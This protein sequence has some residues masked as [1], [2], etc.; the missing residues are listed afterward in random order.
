M[1]TRLS[2]DEKIEALKR[3]SSGESATSVAN[4]IGVSVQTVCNWKK[5]ASNDTTANTLSSRYKSFLNGYMD[6]DNGKITDDAAAIEP[7]TIEIESAPASNAKVDNHQITLDEYVD[8]KAVK[9]DSKVETPKENI[10]NATKNGKRTISL[11][12]HP[13]N[14]KENEM[15]GTNRMVRGSIKPRMQPSDKKENNI[16]EEKQNDEKKVDI[17]E[18]LE[19]TTNI[20]KAGMFK[21][22]HDMPVTLY[23]FREAFTSYMLFSFKKQEEIV[24]RFIDNYVWDKANNRYKKF[25]VYV[26]GLTIAC[27]T[28]I[29]VCAERKISLSLMHYNTDKDSYI[30]QV[31]FDNGDDGA[32]PHSKWFNFLNN[33]DGE[34]KALYQTTYDMLAEA[35]TL[36]QVVVVNEG[37]GYDKN[38]RQTWMYVTSSMTAAWHLYAEKV[39]KIMDTKKQIQKVF[40]NQLDYNPITKYI[41]KSNLSQSY[42]SPN[43]NSGNNNKKKNDYE[44]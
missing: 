37:S 26:S 42:N 22:R 8:G 31:I 36:Y 34:H 10:D 5:K 13:S 18:Y 1:A 17:P 15:R 20:C 19:I 14:E 33:Y 4:D 28:I 9:S 43:P 29:K 44:D 3:I 41:D 12:F 27:A 11:Q 25:C 24:N 39:S 7:T 2:D 32:L 16:V 30:E 23:V 35:N 21:D 6:G 38:Y 40:M